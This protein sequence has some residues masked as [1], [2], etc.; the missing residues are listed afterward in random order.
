MSE[1]I[2]SVMP[3]FGVN[4]KPGYSFGTFRSNS[5]IS[6][7][8][9][10]FTRRDNPGEMRCSHVGFVSEDGG[11]LEALQGQGVVEGNLDQYFDDPHVHIFFRKPRH[12]TNQLGADICA[13]ARKLL[14]KPYDKRL[15]AAHAAAG[16]L[17]GRVLNLMTDEAFERWLEGKMNSPDAWMCAEYTAWTMQQRPEVAGLGCLTRESCTVNPPQYI[18]DSELWTPMRQVDN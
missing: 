16:S 8:I 6:Y 5:I 1:L 17:I 18:F 11:T 10:W 12:Y 3:E 7:G 14:G 15:I 9:A 2:T 4:Y 13:E